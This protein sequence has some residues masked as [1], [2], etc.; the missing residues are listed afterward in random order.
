GLDNEVTSLAFS[1]DSRSLL[2]T[3][4]GY[5]KI[6]AAVLDSTTMQERVRFARHTN[7]VYSGVLSPDGMLAATAGGNDDEIHVWKTADAAPVHRLAG[8]GRAPFSAAWGPD[9][10]TI[11]WGNTSHAVNQ[12]DQGPLERTF[13]LA[14]LEF[15]SAPDA[16]FRRAQ[17][18]RGTL[19]LVSTGNTTVAVRQDDRTLATLA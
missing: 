17:P 6:G 19:A 14:T 3:W 2:I 5:G 13:R 10:A 8:R 4:G 12:N 1:A 7:T 16:S 11:A 9:G 18:T 15:A